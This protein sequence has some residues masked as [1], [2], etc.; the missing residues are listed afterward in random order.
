M[1]IDVPVLSSINLAALVLTIAALVAVF[2]FKLGTLTVI[3]AAA[4]A[5]MLI[6]LAPQVR[7]L[8]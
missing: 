8:G 3:G 4:A 1:Q 2:R 7:A 6:W 5:G